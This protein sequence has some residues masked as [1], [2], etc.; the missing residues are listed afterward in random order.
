LE[1]IGANKSSLKEISQGGSGMAKVPDN[2]IS[3][4]LIPDVKKTGKERY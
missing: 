2:L 3:A 1:G 4:E